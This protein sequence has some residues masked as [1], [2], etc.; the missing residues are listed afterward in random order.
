MCISEKYRPQAWADVIGQP[1]VVAQLTRLRD[2]TG[3]GGSAYWIAGG[4]GRGFVR[5]PMRK[6][7]V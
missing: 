4:S 7:E 2:T 3:L 1:Q 6:G 5:P